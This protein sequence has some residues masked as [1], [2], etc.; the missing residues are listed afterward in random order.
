[1]EITRQEFLQKLPQ[2]ERA[3]KECDIIAIDTELSGLHR[4]PTP[5]RLY[6]MK[7]RYEEYKE[8][9]K[10]F[11][12]IQFG[13]CTFTWDAASNRYIAKPFNSYIFPTS[14]TGQ[15]NSNRVFMT[16]AQAF[17]FLTKQAFD[18]NKWVYQGI[19]YLSK[20][21][22]K[23]LVAEASKKLRDDMPD[24]QIDEKEMEFVESVR[25]RVRAFLEDNVQDDD[26]SDSPVATEE[27][28]KDDSNSNNVK[29]SENKNGI[30]IVTKNAYQRRLVYQEVRKYEGLSPI[31]KQG[32]IRVLKLTKAQEANRKREKLEKFEKDCTYA[33]GFRKIIDMIIE[34]RKPLIGHNMLLDICHMI[35]QFVEPLPDTLHDFKTLVHRLFPNMIDTKYMCMSQRE[36]RSIFVD[37][38]GTGTML[39]TL[40]F[41]TKKGAFQNP[42][43]DVHAEFPRYLTEMAHEAGY[44]AYM[45][46]F[47]FLKL[48]GFLDK[49]RH[50]RKYEIHAAAK[51][52][53]EERREKE[54]LKAAEQRVDADGWDISDEDN[55]DD[56]G[57]NEE[58][59]SDVFDYGS[60]RLN[61]TDIYKDSILSDI[62]NKAALVRTA[63][64]YFDFAGS[65]H[66]S[67][68][69]DALYIIK[70]KEG[71]PF[72]EE[73]LSALFSKYGKHIIEV[74]DHNSAFVVFERLQDKIETITIQSE[75][76]T[77][78]SLSTYLA[79]IKDASTDQ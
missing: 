12:I 60:V 38:T 47:V 64:E 31:G 76:F 49:A 41:E 50:P 58:E 32:F 28:N 19:P 44:D 4:P 11:L 40:F 16:Q 56:H 45:T 36:L 66:I 34:S 67:P 61:L 43:V 1:M 13:L 3:I 37:G 79:T 27:N 39:E 7:D 30:N 42:Y 2:V 57:W 26:M 24:I 23:V 75:D 53:E 25:Q 17:D 15:I 9:T 68:N 21:E 33:V 63:Y 77:I 14:I 70:K 59:D 18:F 71:A 10:R 48:L 78:T 65:E 72:N 5:I 69:V 20:D 73:I 46:G 55:A 54:R 51:K 74:N 52:T 8:A 22:E 62:T 29:T 35:A 6:S